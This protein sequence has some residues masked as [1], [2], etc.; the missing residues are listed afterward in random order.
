MVDIN[1]IEQ[2]V[3]SDVISERFWRR[4]NRNHGGEL[5]PVSLNMRAVAHTSMDAFQEISNLGDSVNNRIEFHALKV[6]ECSLSILENS[7]SIINAAA[8]VIETFSIKSTLKDT[9]NDLFE[10]LYINC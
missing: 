7:L 1:S 2:K 10:L 5:F 6:F 4:E 9:S 3:L 8:D